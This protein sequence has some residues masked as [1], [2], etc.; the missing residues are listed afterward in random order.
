LKFLIFYSTRG[1]FCA[2]DSFLTVQIV[3]IIATAVLQIY[4]DFFRFRK[5]YLFYAHSPSTVRASKADRLVGKLAP[6]SKTALVGGA[7]AGAGAAPA[8]TST[9]EE[10][11]N[12]GA[13]YG[14]T[15]GFH[16]H[17]FHH[18]A[19]WKKQPVV[20]ITNDPLGVGKFETERIQAAGVEA[21]CEYTG[22]DEKG[23]LQVQR[24]PPD[25]AWYYGITA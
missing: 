15:S 8:H 4:I 19:M 18:P 2:R 11:A 7:A 10:D 13:E 16:D 6:T 25:Q 12:A 22:M 14:N 3:L 23:G 21:S 5:D 9:E 17:A 1:C 24:S 20:W